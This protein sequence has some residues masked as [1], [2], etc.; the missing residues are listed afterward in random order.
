MVIS[1]FVQSI[2]PLLAKF[3]IKVPDVR[4]ESMVLD[5]RDVSIKTAFVAIKG[6][7]LDGRE[8]IPQAISLG[9]PAIISETDDPAAHGQFTMRQNTVIIE[10]FNL[11]QALSA[12]AAAFYD[13][14]ASKMTTIAVTGT[15]GKTSVV[16]LLTQLRSELGVKCGLIGTLGS[17]LYQQPFKIDNLNVTINTTPDALKMHYLLADLAQQDVHQVAFEA[18]S[19]ALVQGRLNQIKTDVA[20]F[21]NLTRDHLDYHGTMEEYG[22]AK[23]HLLKQPGLRQLV[24]NANDPESQRWA[25]NTPHNVHITWYG[26]DIDPVKLPQDSCF[27]AAKNII[28]TPHGVSFELY[29]SW[30]TSQIS[31]SLVGKFNVENALAAAAAVLALGTRFSDLLTS[32]TRIAPV[33]GRMELFSAKGLPTVV[34]DYA[35]TPDALE[36][37]LKAARS[38]TNNALWCVFG[39]GGQR[40]KGKRP[41][42]GQVAAEFADQLVLTADNSR[43]ESIHSIIADIK[44]GITK[45]VSVLSIEERQ[46]AIRHALNQANS[47]DIILL[48]GKGHESYQEIEGHRVNYDERAFVANLIKELTE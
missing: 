26:I 25:Q 36:H 4:V 24:L 7:E 46:S 45:D 15:N 34:V 21:T 8:F 31:L 3:G 6:H 40:D 1:Y 37:A 9:A 39:C 19:H 33:P 35:H 16:Q 10:F 18:S 44:S 23:R 48:A 43:N 17:G 29:S 22:K 20:I 2:E 30:G 38:H 5:S 13:Y 27:C 11:S 14:P 41:Q 12:L 32:L 28:T 42:M 47:N